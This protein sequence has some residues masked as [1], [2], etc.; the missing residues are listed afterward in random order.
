V[1]RR[2][3]LTNQ[4]YWLIGG[5]NSPNYGNDDF[6]TWDMSFEGVKFNGIRTTN[7]DYIKREKCTEHGPI[8]IGGT[9]SRYASI[10]VTEWQEV[11][12]YKNGTL[13]LYWLP[14]ESG[15]FRDFLTSEL[16]SKTG[17]DRVEYLV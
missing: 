13:L 4:S 15:T 17:N 1:L 10:A 9:H 14:D 5:M 16:I 11:R 7:S 8:Y 6:A 2:N 12:I 3:N